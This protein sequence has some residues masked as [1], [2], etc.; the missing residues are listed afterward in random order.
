M[1][2]TIRTKVPTLNEY[3]KA[4]RANRYI[5]AKLKADTQEEIGWEILAAAPRCFSPKPI[6]TVSDMTVVFILADKRKDYDNVMF[7]LKFIQDALVARGI[8]HDD[9][10]KWLNPPR[11]FFAYDAADPRIIVEI[12][13][14]ETY[15]PPKEVDDIII[16]AAM[17]EV[18]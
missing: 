16:K 12:A 13:P 11:V 4:E 1:I 5:A 2:F 7:G 18:P 17:K 9:S 10:P 3:I 8:L 6:E 14:S 15:T